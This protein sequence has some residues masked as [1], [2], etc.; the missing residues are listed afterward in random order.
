MFLPR[1]PRNVITLTKT[2]G[3][4]REKKSLITDEARKGKS[5]YMYAQSLYWQPCTFPRHIQVIWGNPCSCR[6]MPGM[7][8]SHNLVT[9]TFPGG[10]FLISKLVCRLP[11]F[12]L[13]KLSHD[14]QPGIVYSSESCQKLQTD[15]NQREGFARGLKGDD[16]SAS[17]VCLWLQQEPLPGRLKAALQF[18]L[19][20]RSHYC[21]PCEPL[22]MLPCRATSSQ[23]HQ[24]NNLPSLSLSLSLQTKTELLPPDCQNLNSSQVHVLT[25]ST[26][27]TWCIQHIW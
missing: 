18:H 21:S 10:K 1:Y 23:G 14:H 27:H 11:N 24:T 2:K 13:E 25:Q 22:F 15:S 19:Y 16:L 4:N 17:K 9:F 20:C 3:D 7:N 6:E 12:A 5:N 8:I 26:L